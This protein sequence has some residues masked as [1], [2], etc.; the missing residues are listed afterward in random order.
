MFFFC[1]FFVFFLSPTI[2]LSEKRHFFS[3]LNNKEKRNDINFLCFAMFLDNIVYCSWLIAQTLNIWVNFK[4]SSKI[5]IKLCENTAR[6]IA[7]TWY[8]DQY[9]HTH[10]HTSELYFTRLCIYSFIRSC[11]LIYLY[12]HIHSHIL[13]KFGIWIGLILWQNL[14]VIYW[15]IFLPIYM[16][17]QMNW[18]NN[19]IL[20]LA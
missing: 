20:V 13:N 12:V 9:R 11:I 18:F 7:S 2:I 4:D 19:Y 10:I 17:I 15:S 8:I 6:N 16:H 5:S 3:V 14:F 1:F